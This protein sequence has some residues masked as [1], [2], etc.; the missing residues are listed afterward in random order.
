MLKEE[1][2]ELLFLWKEGKNHFEVFH[3]R[4]IPPTERENSA[5]FSVKL[6]LGNQSETISVVKKNTNPKFFSPKYFNT[7]TPIAVGKPQESNPQ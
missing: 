1:K 6:I 3:L 7:Y 2:V 5:V 4:L